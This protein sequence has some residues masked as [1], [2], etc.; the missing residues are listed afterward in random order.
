MKK[1]WLSGE[2]FLETKQK[3]K[4][5]QKQQ[6]KDYETMGGLAWFTHSDEIRQL[7][8]KLNGGAY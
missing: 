5:L 7:Y 4:E 6:K 3:I 1:Q 8:R 2:E